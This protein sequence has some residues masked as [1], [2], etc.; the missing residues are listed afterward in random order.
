MDYI[1]NYSGGKVP[2]K[3]KVIVD[4][5]KEKYPELEGLISKSGRFLKNKEADLLEI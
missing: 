5:L 1:N 2:N 4:E 3:E